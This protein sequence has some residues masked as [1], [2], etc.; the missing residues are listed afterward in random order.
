MIEADDS[1]PRR[2]KIYTPAAAFEKISNYCAYQERSH[3]EV[4]NKLYEYGLHRGDVDEILSRLITDGFLNE[5]RFAKAFAGGK[6]RMKKWGRNKIV[7]E[8]EA[9]GVTSRCIQKGLLEIE[10]AEYSKTLRV[11]LKKKFDQ[12]KDENLFKRRDKT[13]RFA[14]GKGYE[15]ELVWGILKE[16]SAP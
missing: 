8:L 2:K 13:A 6:F 16:I 10:N 3:K 4:R 12:T 15:S 7:H 11:L 14:I 1:Q 9:K 5:E